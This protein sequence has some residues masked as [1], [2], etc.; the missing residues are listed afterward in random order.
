MRK[1]NGINRK[2]IMFIFGMVLIIATSFFY[3]N[4]ARMDDFTSLI[5]DTTVQYQEE[6][7]MKDY[8][9]DVHLKDNTPLSITIKA[10]IPQGTLA[11][12]EET[13]N[14]I[15]KNETLTYSLPEQLKVED[16]QANKL[17]LEDDL[18]NSIGS[19]EIKNNVL[20]MSFDEEQINTNAETELKIAL[21]LDTDSSHITY[22]T[23]GSATLLFNNKKIVLNKYVEQPQETT[24][25][26]QIDE[27]IVKKENKS[28]QTPSL[29]PR[30]NIPVTV[31]DDSSTP[32]PQPRNSVDFGEHI[33]SAKVSKIQNGEWVEAREF[34]D[35]D[36]VMVDIDYKLP[37]GVV[38][39]NTKT[40]TYKI[41]EAIKLSDEESG[42]V[43]ASN[44]LAVGTYHITRDGKITIHFN[45]E[46]ATGE[47]FAGYITFSGTLSA[48]DA[49]EGGKVIFG[50]D[51]GE[52]IINPSQEQYD[53][54]MSKKA[55]LNG[56]GT[57]GYTIKASTNNGTEGTVK[58]ED[59]FSDWDSATAKYDESSFT[60]KKVDINGTKTDVNAKPSINGNSFTI[61]KLPQLEAGESYEVTYKA[62]ATPD[63]V[64]GSGSLTNSVKGTSGETSRETS[65][66]IQISNSM[67]YKYGGYDQNTGKMNWTITINPDKKNISG[68][69]LKDQIDNGLTIPTPLTV[70][71]SDG[72]TFEITS[73]PYTFPDGSND[74]YTI[75][76][77][78]D[79]PKENGN[80]NN[81]STIEGDGKTYES[82]ADVGVWHRDWGLTKTAS[83]QSVSDDGKTLTNKWQ[84]YVTLPDKEITSV[85]YSDVI[86]NGTSSDDKG[87]NGEHYAILSELKQEILAN[88]QLKDKDGNVIPNSDLNITMKFYSDEDK[89]K[90]V[91]ANDAHVKSFVVTVKKND[92]SA[93]IGQSL[94]ISSY[95]TIAD[96]KDV[97]EGISYQYV[98]KGIVNKKESE[99]SVH[100]T[101]P[102]KL[103][104][105]GY[106]KVN[107]SQNEKYSSGRVDTNYLSRNGKL[108]YRII[109]TPDSND[110]IS[111][112]DTLP[113]GTKLVETALRSDYK[114]SPRKENPAER[115]SPEA[116]Y[117][118]SDYWEQYCDGDQNNTDISKYF[119]YS[120]D[121]STNKVTF[122]FTPG[123][124]RTDGDWQTNRNNPNRPIAI[125][126]A[127]DITNDEFWNDLMNESKEYSNLLEY[128]G[129][130]QEQETRVER[131][132]Q[133]VSKYGRQ[134]DNTT[135]I[136][137]TVNINPA[138]KDL[139]PNS[140]KIVLRD[141]LEFD[142]KYS[143]YIDAS[144]LKLYEYDS[145][146]ENNRGNLIDSSR[147][148]VQMDIQKNILTITLPDELACVLVYQYDFDVG[149]AATPRIRNKVVL[150]GEFSSDVNTAI[151]T[152]H[153]EAGVVRGKMTI[154]KVDGKDYS[155]TLPGAK[156]RL[157][158]F[159]PDTSQ[160]DVMKDGNSTEFVT[161]KNGEICFAGTNKDRFLSAFNLYRV[162]EI[163]APD[164]YEL[165][166][167]PYYFSIYQADIDKT[168]QD[169]I[170]V[171]NRR[172][173]STKSG[174][175]LN[176][177]VLFVPNNTEVSMYIPNDSNSIYVKKVWV[178]SENK[179]IT[180]HPDSIDVK[181]IQNIK[182]PTGVKVKSHI[183]NINWDK[184]E[185]TVDD[186]TLVVKKGCTLTITLPVQCDPKDASNKVTVEGTNDYTL[187]TEQ[188]YWSKVIL[189][190]KNI[191]SDTNLK[192]RL[193]GTNG[194]VE[195]DYDKDY[196]TSTTVYKTV[197][198]NESNNWSYTWKD[199][200]K[201]VDGHDCVYTLEEDVPSGYQVL[202]TNNDGI[203][204]GNITVTNKKLDNTELPDTGGFGTFG[205]YAIGALF[206]TATLFAII[207]INKKKEAYGK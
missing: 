51:G 115:S 97:K 48:Q 22:D 74:K 108:Y 8:T 34:E 121:Q 126:Y 41:P 49:G 7:A 176:K 120:Y 90:E 156:F 102:K 100:Y 10:A 153:S 24:I 167:K 164:G 53:L 200:P 26:Q 98:N 6:G 89:K 162:E 32:E 73:L 139:D 68:Y 111:F 151:D 175:D 72:T 18:V 36:H 59:K 138:G 203:L 71:K 79:A 88:I 207:A 45:E 197:T 23:N 69:V 165:N 96:L 4:N 147:Y 60:V 159:N 194:K 82:S 199:L 128:E 166:K 202:Y 143:A 145:S 58:I 137:Y 21:V 131:E 86:K 110:E 191:T 19:Y 193:D 56:D 17:Y 150:Q 83:S 107:G 70:K 78:T 61:D 196:T 37:A 180:N 62:T 94:L 184:T 13:D 178:D 54:N 93:F 20:T 75:E 76:Y 170:E 127:V 46:F 185:T 27:Q 204:A 187:S 205:Y 134:I 186:K 140:D 198:L 16:I 55:T 163:E 14:T 81:T 201:Q 168:K 171:M 91:T 188:S 52:I 149:N 35:G 92:N 85:T 113:E 181:L 38:D 122:T 106:G 67:I 95:H 195:Y 183:Y 206:I 124:N 118:F 144:S 192:I 1:Y 15:V 103:V 154:F 190:V 125:Y 116:V 3:L 42:I 157:S 189:T 29:A 87:F 105:Q 31:V 173:I 142:N 47:P 119:Q 155:K 63:N 39:Q 117:Y 152:Q 132:T 12:I 177:D 40:I 9:A 130:E 33:V 80:V 172:G 160:W 136:E 146:K 123:Y 2:K 174:I 101:K 43:Y 109:F 30:T 5:T 179:Q 141:E 65:T 112:T 64:D 84:A 66:T 77:Q 135:K 158:V 28:I 11:R 57:V 161:D 114:D 99:A 182:T 44:G 25:V 169:A 148:Q 133:V 104:K 50:G 129:K